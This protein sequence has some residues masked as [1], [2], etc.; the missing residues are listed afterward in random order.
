MKQLQ[1][2]DIHQLQ[3]KIIRLYFLLVFT[4]DFAEATFLCVF[5]LSPAVNV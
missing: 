3:F 2:T 4:S 1:I 5:P